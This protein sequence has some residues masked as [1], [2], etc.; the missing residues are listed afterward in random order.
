VSFV[1]CL[2]CCVVFMLLCRV[3]CGYVIVAYFMYCIGITALCCA[4]LCVVVVW[5]GCVVVVW[6]CGCGVAVWCVVCGYVVCGYVGGVWGVEWEV[7]EWS[8]LELECHVG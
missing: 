5:C 7:F 2:R 4:A 1:L 8:V 6:L 3:C